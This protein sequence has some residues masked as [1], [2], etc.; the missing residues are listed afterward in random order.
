[1]PWQLHTAA[2]EVLAEIGIDATGQ[3][4]KGLDAIDLDS[5]DAVVTLC[6]DE[7]CPYFPDQVRRVH[8]PLPDPAARGME[9]FRTARD[10]LRE[11]LSAL[12]ADLD[13]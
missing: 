10:E 5:V 2:F 7:V 6:A 3:H 9:S 11:R 4:S 13:A 1:M 8:W 12:F